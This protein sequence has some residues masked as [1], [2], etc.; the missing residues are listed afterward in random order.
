M[1]NHNIYIYYNLI[2]Y[3]IAP[4]LL[5]KSDVIKSNY[6][7]KQDHFKLFDF[8]DNKDKNKVGKRSY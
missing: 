8:C 6:F 3:S 2:K 1:S 7:R 4:S 5:F